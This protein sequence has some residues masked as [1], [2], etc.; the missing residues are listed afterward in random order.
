MSSTLD[1]LS[2]LTGSVC[3]FLIIYSKLKLLPLRKRLQDQGII[4]NSTNIYLITF[5]ELVFWMLPVVFFFGIKEREHNR[6][7]LKINVFWLIML[8]TSLLVMKNQL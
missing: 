2:G 4:K 7:L 6:L 1:I 3:F 5:F 8:L